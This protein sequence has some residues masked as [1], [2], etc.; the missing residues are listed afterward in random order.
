MEESTIPR[1]PI[2]VTMET[3]IL[4]KHAAQKKMVV[5]QTKLDRWTRGSNERGGNSPQ[6]LAIGR[7]MEAIQSEVGQVRKARVEII[8][9]GKRKAFL[10]PVK[11]L[12]V[13]VPAGAGDRQPSS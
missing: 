13:L 10:R 6:Q 5:T 9:D 11:E 12:V 1:R 8:R 3:G 7:I 4:A 2:L